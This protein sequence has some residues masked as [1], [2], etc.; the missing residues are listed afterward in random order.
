MQVQNE[1]FTK[2]IEIIIN[3]LVKILELSNSVNDLIRATESIC[4]KSRTNGRQE[5]QEHRISKGLS[6]QQEV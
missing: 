1:I 2:D 6:L 4:S 5:S 3:N